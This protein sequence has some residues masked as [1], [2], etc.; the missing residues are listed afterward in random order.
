MLADSDHT[1]LSEG[2]WKSI[3]SCAIFWKSIPRWVTLAKR[4]L[5]RVKANPS[6]KGRYVFHNARSRSCVNA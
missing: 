3:V 4:A 1:S 2:L 5:I 6:D